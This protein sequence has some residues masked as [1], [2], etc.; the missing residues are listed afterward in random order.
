M[1]A[2]DARLEDVVME[3]PGVPSRAALQE[4]ASR[5]AAHYP[6]LLRSARRIV[7]GDEVDDLVQSTVEQA[8]RSLHTFDPGTNLLAWL[9]RILSNLTIDQWRRQRRQSTE[10]VGDRAAPVAEPRPEWESLSKEDVEQVLPAL[11]SHLRTAF[12][13]HLGGM[14]YRS[15]AVNLGIRP[16]TVGT[17]LHRARHRVRGLLHA[18]LRR[19]PA[20]LVDASDEAPGSPAGR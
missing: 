9:R 6:D 4:L 11:P 14:P 8:L 1:R 16:S 3:R 17:R 13:L 19:G 7:K 20:L 10:P 18:R 2:A 12:A 5:I 15:I